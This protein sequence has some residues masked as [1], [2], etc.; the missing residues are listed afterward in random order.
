MMGAN[1]SQEQQAAWA[2]GRMQD[3]RVAFL[4]QTTT[5]PASPR[6]ILKTNSQFEEDAAL[7]RQTTPPYQQGSIERRPKK[8]YKDTSKYVVYSPDDDSS[9]EEGDHTDATG[10]EEEYYDEDEGV[11]DQVLKFGSKVLRSDSIAILRLKRTQDRMNIE[12]Q[13]D[14]VRSNATSNLLRKLSQR[15][16]RNELQQ[17]NI[18]PE[19]QRKR[20]E[21]YEEIKAVLERKLSRRPTVKEL[22][23]RRILIHFADY[24]EVI[25]CEDYDRRAD[26]PW[27]RLRPEDKAAIRKELNE[28]K[29]SEMEVH[30]ASEYM[31]RYHKP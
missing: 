1:M 6:S 11:E 14:E 19:D 12:T 27:I 22:R 2:N 17:R 23:D 30:P 31:T 10:M 20:V 7:Q 13:P 26:K 5:I 28:F 29:K 8:H 21:E 24:A 18:I 16:S 3:K 4:A 9:D 25:E 15:P